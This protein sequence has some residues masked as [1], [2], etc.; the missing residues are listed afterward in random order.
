MGFLSILHSQASGRF[1]IGSTDNL[2]RRVAEHERG[3]ILASRGRGPWTLAYSEKFT[4]LAEARRRELEIKRWKSAK[5]IR[6]KV[7]SSRSRA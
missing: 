5:L 6:Q 3:K 1:Y 7:K 4:A 2:D